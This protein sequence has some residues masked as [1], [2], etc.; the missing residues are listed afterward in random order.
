[1]N[2]I[3]WILAKIRYLRGELVLTQGYWTYGF[4][5]V[6]VFDIMLLILF[7]IFVV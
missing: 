5:N 2:Y 3:I 4:V 1:M 6:N 7:K